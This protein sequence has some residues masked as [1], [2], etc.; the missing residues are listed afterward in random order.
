MNMNIE[1]GPGLDKLCTAARMVDDLSSI[2]RTCTCDQ[3][4]AI[5]AVFVVSGYRSFGNQS[6]QVLDRVL[7]MLRIP[8]SQQKLEQGLTGWT[9]EL[10]RGGTFIHK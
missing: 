9:A 1:E 2:I 7:A 3:P 10:V 5:A 4:E 8:T 6:M